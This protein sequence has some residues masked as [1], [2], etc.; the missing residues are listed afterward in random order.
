MAISMQKKDLLGRD[1]TNKNLGTGYLPTVSSTSKT[2]KKKTSKANTSS[3]NLGAYVNN[4]TTYT[5]GGGY[6]ASGTNW[7]DVSKRDISGIL[8]S[9]DQLAD[10]QRNEVNSSYE[11]TRSDLL[12]SLKRFQEQN[13]ID[14]K[15]QQQSYLSE[16][17]G[18]ESARESANRN[19]R[20]SAAARGLGGSGLQQLAQLQNQM[21]QGEDI[22]KAAQN[23]QSAMDALIA[24][25]KNE[26]ED[27]NKKLSNALTT[28]D[29]ALKSIASTLAANKA[30]AQA[31]AD[32]EYTA[33]VNARN[34]AVAQYSY[35]G[36][37]GTTVSN[38]DEYQ[39]GINELSGI[40]SDLQSSLKSLS[41]MSSKELKNYAKDAGISLKNVNKDKYARTIAAALAANASNAVTVANQNYG[42]LGANYGVATNNISK[43]LKYYGY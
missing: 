42:N 29:N 6:S 3:L 21:A 14:K 7:Y 15:N 25:L 23:N 31:Q 34:A 19:S 11:T 4:G 39:Q 35:S 13:A 30:Q 22:S 18:L 26:E 12:T 24:S 28:R 36:S 38:Y 5:T 9:Y 37:P 8:A 32:A 27:T 43:L 33:A 40:T 41:K 10:S 17:A 16:Q 1:V 2:T 20:I